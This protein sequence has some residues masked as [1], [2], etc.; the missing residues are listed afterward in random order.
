MII[1]KNAHSLEEAGSSLPQVSNCLTSRP[2]Q[3]FKASGFS[4][5]SPKQIK[6]YIAWLMEI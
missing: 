6:V 1:F 3:L 4:F 2:K 5:P